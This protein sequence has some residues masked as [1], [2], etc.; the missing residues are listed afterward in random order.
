MVRTRQGTSLLRNSLQNSPKD[1]RRGYLLNE[2]LR[3]LYP[4]PKTVRVIKSRRS[5]WAGQVTKM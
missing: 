5:E 1:D 4:L 2:E 3:N